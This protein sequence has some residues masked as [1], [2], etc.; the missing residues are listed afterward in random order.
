MGLENLKSVFNDLSENQISNPSKLTPHAS[1]LDDIEYNLISDPNSGAGML[2]GILTGGDQYVFELPNPPDKKPLTGRDTSD[3]NDILNHSTIDPKSGLHSPVSDMSKN[4]SNFQ[5]YSPFPTLDSDFQNASIRLLSGQS[6]IEDDKH[7]FGTKGIHD[8]LI[9]IDKIQIRQEPSPLKDKNT[10][11]TFVSK[12]IGPYPTS[13]NKRIID[14]NPIFTN[15]DKVKLRGDDLFQNLGANNRLGEGDFNWTSL[16]NANHTPIE[17]RT[18]IDIGRVDKDGN[19]ILINTLRSGMGSLG[20]LDIMGYS[21]GKL[22]NF[23]GFDRG[24]EPYIVKPIGSNDYTTLVNRDW[25]P[26]NRAKDDMSR[27]VKFYTS[28]AGIAFM[29]K[30]NVTNFL[31]G[32]FDYMNPF[33]AIMAPPL[34][35][36]IQG[37][38][39]F[40][41]ITNVARDLGNKR[42]SLR[43]PIVIEY[44]SRAN[45]GLP[46]AVLGD[47]TVGMRELFQIEIPPD[48]SSI[49]K[50]GLYKLKRAVLNKLETAAQFPVIG[51]PTPFI[52]LKGG[53][54][55]TTYYDHI[56]KT[57][58]E[59]EEEDFFTGEK[60]PPLENEG[61]YINQGDFYVRIKDLRANDF[62]YFRG[63]VTGI[64]ENVNPAF[65]PTNYIGRSEPV[66]LYERAERDL[67]FNLRVYPHNQIEFEL[68]YEKMEK[69]TSLAYPEYF[70]NDPGASLVRMKAP[71]T[72]LYMAHIGSRAQGQ[73]GFI[74]SISYTANESGD[75]DALSALPKLFDIAISY[76]ILNRKPPSMGDKFYRV[77]A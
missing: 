33:G 6:L 12:I 19:A 50:K 46:F 56:A 20:N 2:H 8:Q 76:Q 37:N 16:Y 61:T 62:I 41:N 4:S 18:P 11:I 70:P 21:S 75:W 31:I 29:A 36:P 5:Y 77:G 66:Y 73:F 51:S 39:G 1:R 40:L 3:Y 30:E 72:E 58:V 22:D 55:N 10:P 42:G 38:T 24:N 69:L 65:T 59:S 7:T 13:S 48:E 53:P 49:V 34:P 54:K 45:V 64:T 71:F 28:P 9:K 57:G 17:E 74:K 14:P 43:R 32:K 26:F 27:L 15:E 67:S 47:T 68:M 60:Q 25:I 23:R 35:N 52:D 63:Y 44:S